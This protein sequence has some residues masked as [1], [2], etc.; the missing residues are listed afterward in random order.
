MKY[1]KLKTVVFYIFATTITSFDLKGSENEKEGICSCCCCFDEGKKKGEEKEGE[2]KEENKEDKEDKEDKDEKEKKKKDKKKE[3][4]KKDEEKKE[5]EEG[6]DE[7][8]YE[9]GDEGGEDYEEE[10][11][12]KKEEEKKEVED[13]KQLYDYITNDKKFQKILK[14]KSKKTEKRLFIVNSSGIYNEIIFLDEETKMEDF[15]SYKEN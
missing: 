10:E 12:E 8:G 1:Y 3:G 9:G 4:E 5:E 13:F 11:E 2:N 7:G 6:G 15:F 14:K